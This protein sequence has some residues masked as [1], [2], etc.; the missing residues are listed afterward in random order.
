MR[1][2]KSY[3]QSSYV[4]ILQILI[5]D[6]HSFRVCIHQHTRTQ[7]RV[8]A[9]LATDKSVSTRKRALQLVTALLLRCPSNE[10]W[11]TL[12]LQYVLPGI[13][14]AETTVQNI[15]IEAV[16]QKE[17]EPGATRV[18][19]IMLTHRVHEGRVNAA[20]EKIAASPHIE[21]NIMRIRVE[22]L[23]AA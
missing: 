11:Q 5:Y 17:P 23:D 3:P 18:P 15:S 4:S 19:L 22:T 12:W 8:A 1:T 9:R 20:I 2:R 10:E 14:D 21:N 7:V 16:V 13:H 6:T